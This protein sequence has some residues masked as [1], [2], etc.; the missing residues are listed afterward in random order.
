M[1]RT[2][3]STSS[4]SAA[5]QTPVRRILALSTIALRHVEI[6]RCVDIDVAD[7][8][9]MG[10]HRHARLALH[11]RDQALAAARHDDVDGAV[12]ARKHHADR[13]A[14]AG[15][16]QLR[17]MPPAGRPPP[18][19]D[20]RGVDGAVRAKALRAAAQDRGI[21]GFEAERGG[22]GGH[23]RA[24]LIDDADHAERH[25]HALD[26][27]AVR[28]RPA[29]RHRADRIGKP[30]HD[31]EPRRH[32]LDAL[33][34]ERSRSRNAALAPGGLRFGDV[35]G[36]GRKNSRRTR[37]GSPLAMA[38]KHVFFCAAGASASTA[39]GIGRRPRACIR[40]AKS[41]V[42]SIGFE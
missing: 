36:I 19:L 4:V 18:A 29:L 28:A 34:V 6:G 3:R 11:A 40:P 25:A 8:F 16:H 21:A 5:P 22:V 26:R 38:A 14:V 15:R 2:A 12:E 17:R 23:V 30:A 9:E 27:H 32:G 13:G 33:V 35:L 1:R 37:R 41:P 20:Q 31:L 39:C 10:E 24:A 42:L 7:A